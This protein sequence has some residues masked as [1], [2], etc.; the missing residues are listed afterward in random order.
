MMWRSDGDHHIPTP[1][2]FI[3]QAS[4]TILNPSRVSGRSNRTGS[5]R[6]PVAE[7][8]GDDQPLPGPS[9]RA[10][11]YAIHDASP[12]SLSPVSWPGIRR[13]PRGIPGN[14]SQHTA[15]ISLDVSGAAWAAPQDMA[16]VRPAGCWF[17]QP[18]IRGG[19]RGSE[20][21]MIVPPAIS[22]GATGPT[23]ERARYLLVRRALSDNQV[24][25]IFGPVTKA[26]A[27]RFQRDSHL[28]AAGSWGLPPGLRS[29]ATARSRRH[30]PKD[31]AAGISSVDHR[32]GPGRRR[33]AQ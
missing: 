7:G 23:V 2:G 22:E 9:R 10:R 32:A 13:V 29:A 24:D 8:G 30:W 12:G 17:A 15:G 4:R 21:A 3:P 31:R 18:A 20:Q 1:A 25:G 26:A 6:A 27:G 33:P 14:C 16:T 5:A 19:N 11:G 28:T